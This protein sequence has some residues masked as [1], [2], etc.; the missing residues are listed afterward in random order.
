MASEGGEMFFDFH[1]QIG[2]WR[3]ICWICFDA[4]NNELVTAVY[5]DGFPLKHGNMAGSNRYVST[6]DETK[7]SLDLM[8]QNNPLTLISTCLVAC[9]Q[10]DDLFCFWP[11]ISS[12]IAIYRQNYRSLSASVTWWMHINLHFLWNLHKFRFTLRRKLDY[13]L[14]QRSESS[15]LEEQSIMWETKL[16]FKL[17]LWSSIRESAVHVVLLFS[18]TGHMFNVI[19]VC[20]RCVQ[21]VCMGTHTGYVHQCVV[22]IPA[23]SATLSGQ[24]CS[25]QMIHSTSCWNLIC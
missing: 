16:H 3:H 18:P 14:S 5:T 4:V 25:A 19:A 24:G 15:M 9:W 11:V 12:C 17:F 21:S 7:M 8:H 13:L 20:N 2:R 6:D 22:S 10:A 23:V 1:A